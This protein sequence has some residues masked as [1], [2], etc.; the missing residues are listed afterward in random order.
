MF[1]AKKLLKTKK[2]SSTEFHC[3]HGTYRWRPWRESPYWIPEMLFRASV[4][5]ISSIS[6]NRE[7]M[8]QYFRPGPPRKCVGSEFIGRIGVHSYLEGKNSNNSLS[9]RA[10]FGVVWTVKYRPTMLNIE[11]PTVQGW[12]Q[13]RNKNLLSCNQTDTK[14]SVLCFRKRPNILFIVTRNNK[15]TENLREWAESSAKTGNECK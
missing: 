6:I 1:T 2:E 15:Y 12:R 11:F 4:R 14:K 5:S 10:L 13:R 3:V 8:G 7:V 9:F